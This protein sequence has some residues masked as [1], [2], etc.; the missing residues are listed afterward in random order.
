MVDPK[1]L[2]METY[3][4]NIDHTKI[5]KVE[6]YTTYKYDELNKNTVVESRVK[7]CSGFELGIKNKVEH[8]SRNKF[9]ES[10]K[11]SREGMSFVMKKFEEKNKRIE[12]ELVI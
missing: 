11:R 12:E 8:W 6:E 5:I 1:L 4:R 10:V 9:E 7:F 2:I 3:T